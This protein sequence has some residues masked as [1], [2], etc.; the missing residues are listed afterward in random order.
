M[1][2]RAPRPAARSARLA[3]SD[4]LARIRPD[5]YSE[6]G[7][8]LDVGGIEQS[9][10]DLEDPTVIR[11]EYLRR[12]AHVVDTAAEPGAPMHV[13]HLGAGALTL[14]R[15]VQATRPGSPQ[16]VVEIE[17]ELPGLVT[18]A[19]PLPRGTDLEVRIGDAAQ[20]LADMGADGSARSGGRGRFDVIVV[21]VFS[22]QSTPAHLTR[23]GFFADVLGHLSER[24][25]MAVNVGDDAGLRFFAA[26]AR[27]LDAATEAAGLAGA[28]TLADEHLVRSLDE[29]NLVL[30]AGPGLER[31]R[32]ADPEGLRERWLAGG[33]H[34]AAGLDPAE[35][36]RLI[37]AIEEDAHGSRPAPRPR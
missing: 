5:V 30:A 21:D 24:G 22:G 3:H 29:G 2:H 12:I 8:A 10:V 9:H 14:A 36:S 1:T 25:V 35:T 20:E 23:E 17:R 15:Y 32:G 4:L 37:S 28:W 16:T 18:S 31:S 26:Q 11:H 34:P 19:L 6:H 13:L 7:F 27:A 33:P